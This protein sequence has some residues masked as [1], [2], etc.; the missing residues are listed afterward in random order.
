MGLFSTGIFSFHF[1]ENQPHQVSSAMSKYTPS[2]QYAF[3][4][5]GARM[6]KSA[7]IK[8][9]K[10]KELNNMNYDFL[11]GKTKGR[12][13]SFIWQENLCHLFVGKV[14]H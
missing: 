1:L 4:T 13:S 9:T 5:L 3:I 10:L 2:T 7:H 12:T 8:E 6:M 14:I 11:N